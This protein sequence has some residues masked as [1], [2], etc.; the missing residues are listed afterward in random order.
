MRM[1]KHET[2]TVSTVWVCFLGGISP[3]RAVTL[4]G[5]ASL[6]ARGAW[7]SGGSRCGP[8]QRLFDLNSINFPSSN[9]YLV[10]SAGLGLVPVVLWIPPPVLA[11]CGR[12]L[13]WFGGC[14]G[15]PGLGLRDPLGVLVVLVVLSCSSS[16]GTWCVVSRCSGSVWVVLG[17]QSICAWSLYALNATHDSVD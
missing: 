13:P 8:V 4:W 3:N 10:S 9:V 2:T 12:C 1:R 14:C 5:F 11:E 6:P 15:G 16:G 17:V 7:W